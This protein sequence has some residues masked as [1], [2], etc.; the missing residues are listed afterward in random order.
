MFWACE[1]KAAQ[2]WHDD[3]LVHNVCELLI[4]MMNWVKSKVC[5]NYFIPGNNMMDHLI[6]RDLSYEI[7]AL[8]RT[9]QSPQ[10]I[11]KAIY[12]CHR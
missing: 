3:L 4:E 1:K 7:E 11:S 2:F 6:D 10:L 5:V 9:S 8:W 12:T